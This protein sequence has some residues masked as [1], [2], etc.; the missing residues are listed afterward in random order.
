MNDNRFTSF[1]RRSTLL[2]VAALGA[3]VCV[4]G[5]R[6]LVA[7]LQDTARTGSNS[8]ESAPLA[9]SADIQLANGTVSGLDIECGTFSEDLTSGLFAATG[10]SPG[11][12]SNASLCIKN[13]GSQ[14]VNL[15]VLADELLDL[16]FACTGDE[17]AH[18]DTTCGA[19]GVGELSGVLRVNYRVATCEGTNLVDS[20]VAVLKDNETVPT[21]L[22]AIPAGETAC[23]QLSL[24]YPNVSDDDV[25][26][27]QSDRSTW[28]FKFT[29]QA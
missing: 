5:G 17:E 16:D 6:V 7:A 11:H 15:S 21:E 24:F 8:A 18:G 23:Y 10:V 13:V 25:Q 1:G 19:D 2:T 26:R 14:Q 27:A 3:V 12:A 22:G 9:A 20:P 29:G 28:R 4:I